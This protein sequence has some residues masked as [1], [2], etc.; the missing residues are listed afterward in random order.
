MNKTLY[1]ILLIIILCPG[2]ESFAQN[3]PQTA[4]KAS[5]KIG[6][7]LS[8]GGAKGLAYIGLLKKLIY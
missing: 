7:T 8:G 6:L 5:Q 4:Y 1:K 3:L 2:M